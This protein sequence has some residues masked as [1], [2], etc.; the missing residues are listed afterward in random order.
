MKIILLFMMIVFSFS[1]CADKAYST[2]KVIYV[3][4]RTAYIE[5]D[6]DNPQL[7]AMDKVIVTYDKSRTAMVD[8]I[9]RQKSKKKVSV[10]STQ[11]QE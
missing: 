1:G 5:L 8:E 10:N 4:A 6:I 7:E 9:E 3:G 2:G 11:M